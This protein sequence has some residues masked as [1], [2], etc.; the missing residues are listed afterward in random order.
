MSITTFP[1]RRRALRDLR[2][3][4]SGL[5]LIEFAFSLP[6]LLA[7][8]LYGFETANLAIAHLRVSNVAMLTAD[9]AA[10]VRERID[11]ANVVELLAGASMTGNSIRFAQNGRIILS[12]FERTP[13]GNRQW[14]RWQRC[15]GA[16]NVTSTYGAPKTSAGANITNGTEFFRANRTQA[17]ANPSSP[18]AATLTA[19]G[20]PG[21]QISAVA[22]TAVM[23]VEVAYDYQP[24]V[25]ER[26]FGP[27]RI[28]YESAFNVRERDDQ[29][30]YNANRITP[31]SCNTFSATS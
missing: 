3:C 31:R 2:S 12:S 14:I 1:Q 24:I 21:R 16:L 27:I 28:R 7:L 11:E 26:L 19:V 20:P 18:N 15:T 5:A 13:S 17:S 25:S 4:R 6:V 23:V 30:L 9:N 10:R 8:G 29:T 22:G